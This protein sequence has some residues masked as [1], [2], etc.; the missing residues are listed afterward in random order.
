MFSD[1]KNALIILSLL[2]KHGV[3]K[4]V[5]SPGSTNI[6]ISMGAQKD[7]FFECISVVDE[8]SAA[9]VACGIAESTGQPVAISCTGATASRNYMPGLT[10]AFYRKLPI[11]ALTSFNGHHLVGQLAPQNLDRTA[12]P[13]DVVK[14]S[15]Q[16]PVVKDET[17]AWLC[18]FL[19]NKALTISHI[20][21]GGPVHLNIP[22]TYTGIYNVSEL[23]D[24]RYIK[25]YESGASL[26]NVNVDRLGIFIGSHKRFT[27]EEVQLIDTFCE[28][29]GAV[30]FGDNTSNYRGRFFINP[31]LI[32]ANLGATSAEWKSILPDVLI[33]IGETSGDYYGSRLLTEAKEVWRVS[34]DHELR[35]LG[36]NLTTMF[37]MGV[38]EFFAKNITSE[39][40]STKFYGKWNA[41][42]RQ[43][44]LPPQKLPFSNLWI[45][46]QINSVLSQNIELYLGILNSLRCWN[47]ISLSHHI[48]YVSCNVGGFGIDGALSTVFGAALSNPDKQYICILGD[49][50]FFYD[51][52]ILG[53]RHLPKNLKILL[54]NNGC[55]VEF[56]NVTHMAIQFGTSINELV[57]AG[58]HFGSGKGSLSQVMPAATRSEISRAKAWAQANGI[59]Y[60]SASNYNQFDE[61]LNDFFQCDEICL[62]EC[63]TEVKD[64]SR[65]L[66]VAT[67]LKNTSLETTAKIAKKVLPHSISRRAI[68]LGKKALRR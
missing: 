28:N 58:G 62:L 55:G 36:R 50:A 38:L 32:A 39:I 6:P 17:D 66:E 21:G 4:I 20:N 68:R 14:F 19:V 5:V 12:V 16:I 8:R 25:N 13:N 34:D 46:H 22:S 61:S 56:N 67:T 51:M 31:S 64:E 45:A 26:P 18:N 47:F 48:D 42:S 24:V 27:S 59:T 37:H 60:F 10:E 44:V 33:H 9:Y 40:S 54:V 65:A 1:E 49:L 2:K 3:T 7:P 53:N 30:V 23:P 29:T 41:L 63:F 15:A 11:I 57:A 43:I 52:N 35:D